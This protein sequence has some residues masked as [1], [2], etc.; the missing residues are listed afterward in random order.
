MNF[1]GYVQALSSNG[2]TIKLA[3]ELLLPFYDVAS[4]IAW[5]FIPW[6]TLFSAAW[7]SLKVF[8]QQAKPSEFMRPLGLFVV[9]AICL[10]P[11]PP[12]FTGFKENIGVGP[13]LVYA[14]A[15][16]F[17]AALQEGV[18]VAQSEMMGGSPVPLS[19]L[20]TMN[21]QYSSIFE[22]S[23]VAPILEDYWGNCTSS[24]V[25]LNKHP[26]RHWQSVGL[27]GPGSLGLEPDDINDSKE[28]LRKLTN[29]EEET[30]AKTFGGSFKG[31][32]Q[33]ILNDIPWNNYR[34]DVKPLLEA[35]TFPGGIGR[36]YRIPT[37]AAWRQDLGIKSDEDVKPGP[38]YLSLDDGYNAEE[39]ERFM[40]TDMF[41][42]V[43]DNGED[44]ESY[45]P[46]NFTANDC[47]GLY[48]L[49]HTALAEYYKGIKGAYKVP[50]Y[51]SSE[52]ESFT[53]K[54]FEAVWST[55]AFMGGMNTYYENSAAVKRNNIR[56]SAARNGLDPDQDAFS[57]ARDKA[58]VVGQGVLQSVTAFMLSLNLDQWVLTLMGS[59]ALAIAFLLVLFPFFV[60]FAFISTPG[61]NAV[62]V[63][64]K[65]VLMLQ[66]TL[67][68]A[69]IIA[70]IGSSI[71]AVVNAYA[72]TDFWTGGISTTSIAGLAVAINVGCLVFPLY[73]ARL[74][75]LVLFGSGGVQS[76]S[77][78]TV[79]VGQQA[80]T[81]LIS[82][83][84]AGRM[85]KGA[86]APARNRQKEKQLNKRISEQVNK[87]VSETK[88]ESSSPVNVTL[89]GS[90]AGSNIQPGGRTAHPNMP[91]GKRP[92]VSGRYVSRSEDKKAKPGADQFRKDS[93]GPG[94][95]DNDGDENG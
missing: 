31:K 19:A 83:A 88:I 30:P 5:T 72:A 8:G 36:Y 29:G 78:Q 47:F 48:Q 95:T 24:V 27:L 65:I 18:M 3:M 57:T 49:A 59:L 10:F 4:D 53:F 14:V 39:K 87:A 51:R 23:A 52:G 64:F 60:P 6:L 71:M 38:R 20:S 46:R 85:I 80:M 89:N 26:A 11:L 28:Y 16:S 9:I 70:S 92:D 33:G 17:N 63:I 56:N 32:D 13:Y 81:T 2:E 94:N 22:N 74:A 84:I 58:L 12:K 43:V 86:T 76:T 77:G 7:V 37:A 25:D 73:A 61:E 69:Y 35:E 54:P 50:E 44:P 42:R 67:S 15:G 41:V 40:T 82:G 66:L 68:L 34:D 62:A 45:D 91:T 90:R 93:K 1:S 21:K 55:S 79:S 75:F